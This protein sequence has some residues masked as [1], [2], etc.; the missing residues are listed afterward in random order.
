MSSRPPNRSRQS[1]WLSTTTLDGPGG[2]SLSL[3]SRPRA[4]LA[5]S[6][7]KRLG[8]ATAA[9]MRSGFSPGP[10]MVA[11]EVNQAPTSPIV[12]FSMR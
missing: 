9:W 8:V 6:T 11:V 5:P 3:M 7:E 1:A 12:R 2:G 10:P 4:G